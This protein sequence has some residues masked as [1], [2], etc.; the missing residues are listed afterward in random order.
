MQGYTWQACSSAKGC[1]RQAIPKCWKWIQPRSLDFSHAVRWLTS[2]YISKPLTGLPHAELH[3]SLVCQAPD[4]QNCQAAANGAWRRILSTKI[5]KHRIMEP[6][7]FALYDNSMT[8]SLYSVDKNDAG[9]HE[10][11][12]E[13]KGPNGCVLCAK[14]LS[15]PMSKI[16][17]CQLTSSAILISNSVYFII[18]CLVVSCLM[19][20]EFHACSFCGYNATRYFTIFV[21]CSESGVM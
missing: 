9:M 3:L 7:V 14:L 19:S 17:V 21:C 2:T 18:C 15:M 5:T 4:I 20:R 6:R 10:C 8:A 1:Q 16:L 13:C 12:R 11:M